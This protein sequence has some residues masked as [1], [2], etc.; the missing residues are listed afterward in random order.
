MSSILLKRGL[1]C[2]RGNFQQSQAKLEKMPG[3]IK[4]HEHC[5]K[6][7]NIV[8]SGNLISHVQ[9][10]KRLEVSKQGCAVGMALMEFSNN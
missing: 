1:P 4:N 8:I 7:K 5:R 10:F 6:M 3:K 2:G 9:H